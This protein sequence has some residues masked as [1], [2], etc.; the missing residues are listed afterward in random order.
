[1]NQQQ[2]NK[3]HEIKKAMAQS[4]AQ[5]YARE[6]KSLDDVMEKFQD[7][8]LSLMDAL[9]N[10]TEEELNVNIKGDRY[11]RLSDIMVLNN[12]AKI[13][14]VYQQLEEVG[15]YRSEQRAYERSMKGHWTGGGF[16]LKGAIKGAAMAGVLN[17]ATNAARDFKDGMADA[18]DRELIQSKKREFFNSVDIRA[19]LGEDIVNSCERLF[20]YIFE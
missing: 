17:M 16:G 8:Y 14:N 13:E 9:V 4:F 12:Y 18:R 15:E 10:V 19:L 1:M 20:D 11:F 3:C 6:I 7:I 5:I 2:Y